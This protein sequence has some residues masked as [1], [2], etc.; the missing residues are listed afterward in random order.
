MKNDIIY[1]EWVEFVNLNKKYIKYSDYEK[2]WLKN[3]ND[4]KE[5]IKKFN[6]LPSCTQNKNLAVWSNR[7]KDGKF[8]GHQ[9]LKNMWIEFINTKEIKILFL[10]EINHW[11]YTLN[12]LYVYYKNNKKFP[13]NNTDEMKW[14]RSNVIDYNNE[15][16]IIFENDECN[17]LWENFVNDKDIN[18]I[19]FGGKDHEKYWHERLNS[20]QN[21]IK[22]NNK[23]PVSGKLSTKEEVS[24]NRWLHRQNINYKENKK[25]MKRKNIKVE[26]VK[27]VTQIQKDNIQNSGY[28]KI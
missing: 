9:H 18:H 1:N 15:T 8:G 5:H 14:Y 28:L 16:G 25:T 19:N 13:Q 22:L 10:N 2:D 6:M 7:Q 3:F 26:W 4:Y 24:D 27:F 21:Y 11:K 12:Y 17:N 20:I 23:L